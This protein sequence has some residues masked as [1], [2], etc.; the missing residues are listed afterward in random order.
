MGFGKNNII[1]PIKIPIEVLHFYPLMGAVMYWAAYSSADFVPEE[2]HFE[3]FNTQ[4][5]WEA[6]PGSSIIEHQSA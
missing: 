3:G 4:Q 2:F 6:Q 5:H 1:I